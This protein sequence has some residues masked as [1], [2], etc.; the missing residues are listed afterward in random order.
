MNTEAITIHSTFKR[1]DEDLFK[2]EKPISTAGVKELRE[3]YPGFLDLF[4]NRIIHIPSDNDS[5][6][7][8]NLNLFTSDKDIN[9][10]HKKTEAEFK[11]TQ[12][13]KD[14]LFE[15]LKRYSYYFPKKN[16]P[17]VITYISAFNYTVITTDSTLGI[18]LDMYL[19]KDCVFY[20]ALGL[21]K[22]MADKLSKEYIVRDAI[23][24]LFQSD[25]D[26]DQVNSEF[27]SQLVYQGKLLYF[28]DRLAPE[29][30]DSVKIG[31]SAQQLQ[32]CKQNESNIW[33]FM[34]ENNLLYTKDPARYVRYINDG[35]GTQGLPKE[36]PSKLGTWIGWAIANAYMN[37]HPDMPLENFLLET[38]A[39]KI[40]A[41]SGYKPGK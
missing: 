38:D 41:E 9:E 24:A 23:K 4:C 36:A 8:A 34:I 31:F 40:L 15:M 32:W 35:P 28:M 29:M 16:V 14:D 33:G 39:Q 1:F 11:D 7:A 6:I 20:P 21:P 25:F 13:L 18:G 17:S 10:I 30:E 3:S 12:W 37:K 19:G 27:I 26:P 2:V 5:S 22:Y